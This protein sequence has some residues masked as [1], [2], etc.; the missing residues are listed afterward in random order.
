MPSAKASEFQRAAR[1][2]GYQLVR[3]SG[4]HSRWTND[5]GRHVTIPVHPSEEIGPQLYFKILKQ[6]G[7][8]EEQ[9]RELR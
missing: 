1:K 9:F 4:S 3:Q 7:I 6:L 5:E 2:L 8:T